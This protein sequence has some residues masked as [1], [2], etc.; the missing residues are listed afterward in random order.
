MNDT[1]FEQAVDAICN[2][3]TRYGI[4]AYFFVREALDFTG[5]N[6]KKPAQGK[7]RHVSGTELLEGIRQYALQEFGPMSLTVL[8]SWGVH[9]TADFGELVFNLVEAGQL[10]KTEEDSRADFANSYDFHDVFAKP[11]LPHPPADPKED[12]DKE[13]SS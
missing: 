6:L 7:K 3:D 8:A 4:D 2:Q 1:S 10:G 5:K 9:S 11:F 12:A 13:N